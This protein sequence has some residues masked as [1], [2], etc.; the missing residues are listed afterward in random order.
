MAAT[1][2]RCRTAACP[3]WAWPEPM[4]RL[5]TVLLARRRL[6]LA[7][8]GLLIVL[9]GVFAAGLP[10]RIVP[11]GEAP[12]S[13]Q[14]EVVARAL[15]HSSLPSL[16]VA[17]RV[18]PGTNPETPG[19]RAG[20]TSS[21]AAAALRVKGVTGVSP[22]PDTRPVQ[23]DGAEVIVLNISASGGT[24]G[25]VKTAHALSRLCSSCCSS[26]SGRCGP[27]YCRWRSR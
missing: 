12:A 14:S 7:V 13:S 3:P 1:W 5:T 2:S 23:P 9:D 4:E 8:W 17:I 10:G 6:V 27:P 22:M 21:V 24:D 19:Q 11:G 16:F 26:P 25:A 15:A 18:T 20:L